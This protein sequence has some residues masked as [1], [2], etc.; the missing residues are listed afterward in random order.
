[1]AKTHRHPNPTRSPD[2]SRRVMWSGDRQCGEAESHVPAMDMYETEEWLTIELEL[3]GL[4]REAIEVWIEGQSV[5]VKAMKG[6]V[7][8]GADR[9]TG[10]VSYQQVERKFGCFHREIALPIPC[11]TREARARFINGVLRLEF[12]KILNRRGERRRLNVE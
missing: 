11:N 8:P 7:A 12:K 9:K 4:R 1:M 6:D 3:P 2:P 5:T 10:K